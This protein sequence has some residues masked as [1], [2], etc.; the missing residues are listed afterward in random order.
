M[1]CNDFLSH[2]LVNLQVGHVLRNEERRL[3]ESVEKARDEKEKT[4]KACDIV[5]RK[6]EDLKMLLTPGTERSDEEL[7]HMGS[8]IE[9]YRKKMEKAEGQKKS[10]TLAFMTAHLATMEVLGVAREVKYSERFSRKGPTVV[11]CMFCTMVFDSQK[12]RKRHILSYHWKVFAVTVS[13]CH[14]C[15]KFLYKNTIES[16]YA[17]ASIFGF[18]HI[19]I[20]YF[21]KHVI[22]FFLYIIEA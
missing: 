14:K 13:I 7:Q 16:V 17:C 9:D 8:E 12:I 6:A 18:L 22:L 3:S 2:V 15:F 21:V 20:F 1:S 4:E 5:K 10:S 19:K 11:R